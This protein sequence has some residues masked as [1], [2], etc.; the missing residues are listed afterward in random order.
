[1]GEEIAKQRFKAKPEIAVSDI[2]DNDILIM[3]HKPGTMDDTDRKIRFSSLFS[4]IK[5]KFKKSSLEVD[6]LTVSGSASIDKVVNIPTF[7]IGKGSYYQAIPWD[8]SLILRSYLGNDL[9]YNQIEFSSSSIVYGSKDS[10]GLRSEY[11]PTISDNEAVGSKTWSSAKLASKMESIIDDANYFITFPNGN[12]IAIGANET[13]SPNDGS[14]LH[15]YMTSLFNGWFFQL[16]ASHGTGKLFVRNGSL[17]N[18]S[19]SAWKEI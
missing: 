5:E 13:N 1:M 10:Q 15:M 14:G 17:S 4:W 3:E 19:Q 12:Y 18:I 9:T 7:D 2:Q 6:S 8:A 11:I 16:C